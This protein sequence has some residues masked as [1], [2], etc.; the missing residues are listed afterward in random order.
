VTGSFETNPVVA[1]ALR[2]KDAVVRQLAQNALWAIWFRADTPENN[3][4]LEQIRKVLSQGKANEAIH[5][6]NKL[7]ERA[8]RF[9]EAYNQR[10]IGFF[11]LK[12]YQ[13]SAADCR[14]VLELNP[15][16][17]GSLAGLAK[18]YLELGFE[19]EA[20]ATFKRASA[21][22]PFDDDLKSTIQ[23]LEASRR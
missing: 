21:L 6:A 4:A 20:L 9:A 12:R 15:F 16:H 5:L 8:P 13:E 3:A 14:R 1:R 18:C 10:A 17:F 2:D 11:G 22:Q 19:D 23:V 7:I